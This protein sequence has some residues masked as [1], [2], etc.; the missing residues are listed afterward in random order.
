MSIYVLII[1]KQANLFIKSILDIFSRA[2]VN[3]MNKACVTL[4]ETDLKWNI[5][6]KKNTH[7]LVF[8]FE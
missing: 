1:N 6:N 2:I 4:R 3:V 5:T 7:S 8:M